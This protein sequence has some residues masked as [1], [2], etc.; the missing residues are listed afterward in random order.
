MGCETGNSLPNFKKY[1]YHAQE[2]AT[3]DFKKC[4][5]AI[6]SWASFQFIPMLTAT[7]E[8][9]FS[10]T[11]CWKLTY[12]SGPHPS[13][14]PRN[15]QHALD[16]PKW[17]EKWRSSNPYRESLKS[18]YNSVPLFSVPHF[19]SFHFFSSLVCPWEGMFPYIMGA[20]LF[21]YLL[22][23]FDTIT[24]LF[25]VKGSANKSDTRLRVSE[26]IMK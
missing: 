21:K 15:P 7:W 6:V 9:W 10:W 17:R 12:P 13:P 23:C 8:S 26:N 5:V 25:P 3:S 11:E 20:V 14:F 2:S 4:T 18:H 1:V 22:F 19:L 24:N 16:T